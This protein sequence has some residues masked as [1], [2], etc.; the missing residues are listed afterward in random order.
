ML[1]IVLGVI[2]NTRNYIMGKFI[3]KTVETEQSKMETDKV[4]SFYEAAGKMSDILQDIAIELKSPINNIQ[5][6]WRNHI[7][8]KH[9]RNI[10]K[11]VSEN[12]V[13]IQGK[14]IDGCARLPYIETGLYLTCEII[15]SEKPTIFFSTKSNMANPDSDERLK[16]PEIKSGLES[17][18]KLKKPEIQPEPKKNKVI[19]SGL[20]KQIQWSYFWQ[21]GMSEPLPCTLGVISGPRAI[22]DAQREE[23][24]SQMLGD[25]SN[26]GVV[27]SVRTKK[28]KRVMQNERENQSSPLEDVEEVSVVTYYAPVA[29]GD[30]IDWLEGK[31]MISVSKIPFPN[32][33]F[34]L[35]KQACILAWIHSLGIIWRDL[36]GDNFLFFDDDENI[37]IPK[38][39][40]FSFARRVTDDPK[41]LKSNLGSPGYLAPEHNEF[42][43]LRYIKINELK[44]LKELANLEKTINDLK[45]KLQPVPDELLVQM[46]KVNDRIA[47]C[48]NKLSEKKLAIQ[49]IYGDVCNEAMQMISDIKHINDLLPSDY[50]TRKSLQFLSSPKDDA[51]GLSKLLRQT[52]DVQ[53]YPFKRMLSQKRPFSAGQKNQYL[54]LEKLIKFFEANL[55]RSRETRLG[56][57]EIVA[58]LDKFFKKLPKLK[59]HDQIRKLK[60][61]E[62]IKRSSKISGS[63]K[64]F[65]VQPSQPRVL[66]DKKP[67]ETKSL[68]LSSS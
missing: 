54:I 45:L 10:F 16:E 33:L 37:L 1:Y 21:E 62:E 15:F 8:T 2:F 28:R 57:S 65:N 4:D 5:R 44:L 7:S 46:K 52:L 30:H 19:A 35:Y 55:N 25:Y 60:Q 9:L 24:Y 36:K 13:F 3:M 27:G 56:A 20:F 58:E 31:N 39:I 68:S 48:R 64:L 26:P 53:M 66:G 18:E 34:I 63:S 43:E 17:D 41:L 67:E 47:E 6:S 42:T 61:Q 32:L 29:K 22:E 49:K 11:W 59:I 38:A 51:W 14:I 23:Q 12:K 40:D 50:P